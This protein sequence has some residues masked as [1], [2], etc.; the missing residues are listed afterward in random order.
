MRQTVHT[1]CSLVGSKWIPN[2][3]SSWIMANALAGEAAFLGELNATDVYRTSF[4]DP[5]VASG[6]PRFPF[7]MRRQPAHRGDTDH[8]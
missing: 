2:G 4:R 6:P 3:G 8:Q 1:G 7:G 5:G